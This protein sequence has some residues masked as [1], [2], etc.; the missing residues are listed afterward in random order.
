MI[1]IYKH[2]LIVSDLD[3]IGILSARLVQLP[4]N[5]SIT[6]NCVSVFPL[7]SSMR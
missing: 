4:H 3:T 6:G 5:P 1:S 7:H 2:L